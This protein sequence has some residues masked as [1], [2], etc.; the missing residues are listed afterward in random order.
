MA[1]TCLRQPLAVLQKTLSRPRQRAQQVFQRTCSVEALLA[2]PRVSP[3]VRRIVDSL[4]SHGREVSAADAEI[5]FQVTGDDLAVLAR[6]ANEVRRSTV[7]GE[8]TYVVN[9]NIN[10]T[11][12]CVKRCGFCAFSRT[13][14]DHEGYYLPPQEVL[15]RAGEAEAMGATEV[16]IQAGLPPNMAGSLYADL[17]RSIKAKHPLLHIHAFS[18]EEVIW[19]VS[20][21][22]RSVKDFLLELKAAG[23]G[24]LPGTSAEI[25]DNDLRRRV[26]KGRLSVEQWVDVVKTAHSIGLPT[27]STMM[28]G[29]CETPRQ[30]ARHLVLLR[31]LQ[32]Q[33]QAGSGAAFTEFVPLGFVAAEAPLWKKAGQ[34]S[35]RPGPTGAEVLR[36]HAVARLVFHPQLPGGIRNI[37]V[38]WVKEGLK[39]AQLL[40]DAGANDLGGT[41][42]NESISTAAGSRHG[43]LAKPSE[44]RRLVWETGPDRSVAE[45]TTTYEIR[46]R[47]ENP[48]STS[49]EAIAA[50]ESLAAKSLDLQACSEARVN[51]A[52][53]PLEEVGDAADTFGSFHG[54]VRSDGFRFKKTQRVRE[55]RPLTGGVR[56]SQDQPHCRGFASVPSARRFFAGNGLA[57]HLTSSNGARSVTYSPSFTLVP[58]YE[59]FNVCT[60]CNFRKNVTKTGRD[61]L[62]D[63][64]AEARLKQLLPEPGLNKSDTP[65]VVEILVMSGEVHPQALNRAAWLDRAESICS[66]A[67]ELGFL[68]H[69]N[70]GPLD[71]SEMARLAAVNASMGLM[72]EQTASSLRKQGGVHRFAPSKEPSL[73]IAQLRQAGELRV[74]F[75]TGILVGIGETPAE[76]LH[77]LEVIAKIAEEFGHVQEVI[78]QPHSMGSTQR[79]RPGSEDSNE[80]LYGAESIA[81][82]P[83]LVRAA[84]AML[85]AAVEIQVPPNLFLHGGG[86]ACPQTISSSPGWEVLIECLEAGASDL[87]GISP[88]DEV[89]PDF[90]FPLVQVLESAL[91]KEGFHLSPRLPVYSQHFSWLPERVQSVLQRRLLAEPSVEDAGLLGMKQS[92]VLATV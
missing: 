8:V 24:S 29:F 80:V 34:L 64:D 84:R 27:T 54:L 61:W 67:L 52:L 12:V 70:I 11:N 73:R 62:S 36:A 20:R 9:R 49:W 50:A 46:R 60:Y 79:L 40:L 83:S 85:P 33:A 23:V 37:Q 59:C 7:G 90:Q 81:A 43:Q 10:F 86:K 55:H 6:A 69:T 47:F 74:P 75:T 71:R 68:P 82:L 48:T 77:T 51:G 92:T 65:Q 53:Q 19:G 32:K 21:S 30:L 88:R 78:I 4:L 16:C 22:G 89:N 39:M 63:D 56:E 45:R 28:F 14:V 31:D 15:R 57:D 72:L 5:L 13:G 1:V 44:L 25:L 66:L 42:M 3:D 38:S 26:A 18:P 35:V 76:R 17:C 91:A 41:L 87:G 58:T 2:G